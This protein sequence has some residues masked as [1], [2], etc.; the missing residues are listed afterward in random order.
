MTNQ[1]QKENRIEDWSANID[2]KFMTKMAAN[3]N[4]RTLWGRTYLYSPYEGVPPPRERNVPKDSF[5]NK[6]KKTQ[7]QPIETVQTP[8]TAAVM[9]G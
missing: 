9:N 2:T 4:N 8:S 1:L 5:W 3:G 7:E 6:H